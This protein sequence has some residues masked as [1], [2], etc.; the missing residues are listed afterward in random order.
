[1]VNAI[2]NTIVPYILYLI[3][4]EWNVRSRDENNF[5]EWNVESEGEVINYINAWVKTIEFQK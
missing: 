3:A 2:I 4:K 5:N 1:M